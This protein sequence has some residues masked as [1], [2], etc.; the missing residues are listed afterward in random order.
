MAERLHVRSVN[1][2]FW[3]ENNLGP[4][5]ILYSD[6][7]SIIYDETPGV[8]KKLAVYNSHESTIVWLL[9]VIYLVKIKLSA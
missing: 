2:V 6:R 5:V 3:S 1:S 9:I 7:A 8:A 4:L